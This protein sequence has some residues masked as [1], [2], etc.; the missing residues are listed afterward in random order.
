[1]RTRT[2]TAALIAAALLALTACG[3][4]PEPAAPAA[5]PEPTTEA[6]ETPTADPTPA[7]PVTL[8]MGS[9]WEFESTTDDIEGAVTVLSYKQGVKSVGSAAEESGTP[10][11]EWA[12]VD[13]K[14]CSTRGTFPATTEPWTLAYEDGSRVDPSSTTYDDFPKPEFPFETT[15]TDGKCVRGKLVFPVPGDQRPATVVYAPTGLD[16]PQEWAVPAK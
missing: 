2:T 8:D 7:A 5:G 13:M 9:T 1:M 14:T 6:A 12:Y 15:L 3:T 4:E 11:Y 10:G 16:V